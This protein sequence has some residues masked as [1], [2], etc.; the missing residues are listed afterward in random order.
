MAHTTIMRWVHQYGPELNKRI[1]PFQKLTNSPNERMKPTSK[2][3]GQWKYLYMV[4]DS[5]G[6]TIDFM[7]SENRHFSR[8][9]TILQESVNFTRTI[10]RLSLIC[11]K[12]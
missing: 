9:Q 12:S 6:N 10:W 7:P 1:C 11:F 2:S 5:K 3:K 4:V 8:G